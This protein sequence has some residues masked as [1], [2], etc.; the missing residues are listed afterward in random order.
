[1]LHSPADQAW[2]DYW[3]PNCEIWYSAEPLCWQASL[4]TGINQVTGVERKGTIIQMPSIFRQGRRWIEKRWDKIWRLIRTETE[5]DWYRKED[6]KLKVRRIKRMK[7]QRNENETC[8]GYEGLMTICTAHWSGRT[9]LATLA[10]PRK[11][12]SYSWCFTS[13][14][15]YLIK[16]Y[17]L[18]AI[19]M[20]H[21]SWP[22]ASSVWDRCLGLYRHSTLQQLSA[23]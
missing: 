18:P 12:Y 20:H 9:T 14:I 11:S 23:T 10:Q 1:M 6:R 5:S 15:S 16:L 21:Q 4:V 19:D 22:P 17:Y 8:G 7:D 3:V 13:C 2:N